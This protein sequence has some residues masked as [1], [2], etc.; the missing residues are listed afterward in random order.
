MELDLGCDSATADT[1]AGDGDA[2]SDGDEGGDDGDDGSDGSA[3]PT[4][5]VGEWTGIGSVETVTVNQVEVSR[6]GTSYL[7]SGQLDALEP[8]GSGGCEPHMVWDIEG[9]GNAK[10]ENEL[11]IDMTLTGTRTNEIIG[12]PATCRDEPIVLD[13]DVMVTIFL[14]ED[15]SAEVNRG[16]DSFSIQPG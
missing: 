16:M 12:G 13:V 7:L 11:F 6:D 15:H 3:I 2:P 14:E 1:S 8:V 9:T 4:S 5:W 10:P